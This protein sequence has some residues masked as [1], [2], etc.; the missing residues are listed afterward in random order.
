M[1]ADDG[2]DIKDYRADLRA[3]R[4]VLFLIT[5]EEDKRT[6]D[7]RWLEEAAQAGVKVTVVG[8]I[9]E[10]RLTLKYLT[11]GQEFQLTHCELKDEANF[12]YATFK[13]NLILTGSTFHKEALFDRVTLES[14]TVLTGLTFKSGL[15]SFRDLT[16]K[17]A[18]SAYGCKFLEQVSEIN[19]NRA[20]FEKAANFLGTQ[21]AAITSFRGVQ[22]NDQAAFQGARFGAKTSFSRARIA[23][24]AL[25]REERFDDPLSSYPAATFDGDV[26]FTSMRV[27]RQAIFSGAKFNGTCTFAG[28][29]VGDHASMSGCV[30]KKEAIFSDSLF[31][32]DLSLDKEDECPAAIFEDLATFA[33]TRFVKNANFRGTSFGRRANFNNAVFEGAAT[34]GGLG[35]K[36]S[37][38]EVIIEPGSV[39]MAEASFARV[40]FLG[41]ADFRGAVF[42]ESANFNLAVMASGAFFRSERKDK[43]PAARFFG[44]ADFGS[45]QFGGDADFRDVCFE[46][47]AAFSNAKI[48]GSAR[49]DVDD[50]E[51]RP[52]VSFKNVATFI[53]VRF[54]G[55]LDFSGVVFEGDAQFGEATIGGN[56]LFRSTKFL[57]GAEFGG[58]EYKRSAHYDGAAFGGNVS[59]SVAL[60]GAESFF[61]DATFAEGFEA[62]FRG[63][64]FRSTADFQNVKFDGAVSF[65]AVRSDSLMRF[66]NALFRR[67]ADFQTASFDL[68]DFSED[69]K[70]L[71]GSEQFLGD[72]DFRGCTYTRL[73]IDWQLLAKRMRP[74]DRQ[75]YTQLEKYFRAGGHDSVADEIYLA[76][77]RV[78]R[79]VKLRRGD[80]GA[81]LLSWAYWVFLRNGVR[82][83]RLFGFS[84]LL[85]FL[86]ALFFEMPTTVMPKQ[87]AERVPVSWP[88]PALPRLTFPDALAFSVRQFLPVDIPMG[89]NWLP[90]D[91]AVDMPYGIPLRVSPSIFATLVLRLPGWLLLP[92][93]VAGFSGL[94]RR[95]S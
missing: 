42:R 1:G 44:P 80:Y 41:Q 18:F 69:G 4:P 93:L 47:T 58:V 51:Q 5:L 52:S 49:F 84:V 46:G 48:S 12:S 29:K 31:G 39:F 63:A 8:A 22:F 81:Y 38:G 55:G 27:D 25:F 10:G 94:A 7:A 54:D 40:N 35:S 57:G 23:D 36:T 65:Y 13:Q 60:F 79:E 67:E 91:A 28:V 85:I 66:V 86:G 70:G 53:N 17:G 89:A 88:A 9:I 82:P 33:R 11:V 15:A 76:R 83:F 43:L 6:I 37:S 32:G 14:D 56:A 19:F 20:C 74:Y 30:F 62:D 24:H 78:E 64:R 68:I 16:A 3:G 45:V 87:A 73:A 21:F 50:G 59:F 26:D 90:A 61:G 75:S 2:A 71:D 77:E 34:F 95:R 92:L 72:V